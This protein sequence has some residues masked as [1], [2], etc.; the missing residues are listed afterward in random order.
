MK[1]RKARK[2]KRKK[3][4]K[5]GRKEGRD[6][7]TEG[8]RNG[9]TEERRDGGTEGGMGK[10]SYDAALALPRLHTRGGAPL[11]ASHESA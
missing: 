5:E 11:C 9:G 8:R 6:G 3:E 4:R 7:G 1:A 2:R 10:K